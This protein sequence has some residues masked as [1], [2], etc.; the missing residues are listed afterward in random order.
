MYP[1]SFLK[2]AT[3]L[4]EKRTE[5]TQAILAELNERCQCT[6]EDSQIT[7]AGFRCFEQSR[8]AVTFRAGVTGSQQISS[9]QLINLLDEW[10]A[11]GATL[12]VQAQL[13][14]VDMN[15]AVAISSFSDPECRTDSTTTSTI[16][17][18]GVVLGGVVL[19]L[20]LSIATVAVVLL[21]RRSKRAKVD[22]Q[23]VTSQE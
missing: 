10:V 14:S 12:F 13:L 20:V 8:T 23:T 21:L 17:V 7:D 6:V 18:V 11:S 16:T 3:D 15:C 19:I 1:L 9:Q 22:L 4:I 2:Q 5:V